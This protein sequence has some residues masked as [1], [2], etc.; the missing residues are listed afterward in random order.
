MQSAAEG[1]NR[2]R[3][4]SL[5]FPTHPQPLGKKKPSKQYAF[6]CKSQVAY[7]HAVSKKVATDFHYK[8]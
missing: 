8:S 6:P 3:G 4:F 1:G 7:V 2:A 5:H